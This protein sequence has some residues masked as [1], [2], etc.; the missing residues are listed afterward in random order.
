VLICSI[1]WDRDEGLEKICNGKLKEREGVW[2][3]IG[4]A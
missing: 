3:E 4:T 1:G 2:I